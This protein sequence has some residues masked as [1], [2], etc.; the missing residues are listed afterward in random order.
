MG[1]QAK[2]EVQKLLDSVKPFVDYLTG[3]TTDALKDMNTAA[4]GASSSLVDFG[5]ALDL[6]AARITGDQSF[7]DSQNQ[8]GS[9]NPNRPPPHPGWVYDPGT[10][11]WGPPAPSQ[12]GGIR[13]PGAD[14]GDPNSSAWTEPPKPGGWPNGNPDGPPSNGGYLTASPMRGGQ[15]KPSIDVQQLSQIVA[16]I[17]PVLKGELNV[18]VDGVYQE[19]VD[20]R[21]EGFARRTLI[22]RARR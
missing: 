8:S 6:L 10:G 11:T 13:V 22:A 15:P 14:P 20:L 19:T 17:A 12:N 5:T 3:D 2:D 7:T 1:D 16:A 4:A 18:Y 9:G 21:A